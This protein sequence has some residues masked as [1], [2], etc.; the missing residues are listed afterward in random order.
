MQLS[1]KNMNLKVDH[2][3]DMTGF[4][5]ESTSAKERIV[6]LMDNHCI[7]EFINE[8]DINEFFV[9]QG[10]RLPAALLKFGNG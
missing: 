3:V 5:I 9:N 4:D 2:I 7:T 1:F 10:I 8:N 6:Q